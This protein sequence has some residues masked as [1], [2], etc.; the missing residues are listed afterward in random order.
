MRFVKNIEI[1]LNC[2]TI[3]YGQI[4]E[5]ELLRHF[6]NNVSIYETSDSFDFTD[7]KGLQY[8]CTIPP[9]T[10]LSSSLLLDCHIIWLS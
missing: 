1:L 4:V 8:S 6:A 3:P 10:S 5:A 2:G 7:I 9:L